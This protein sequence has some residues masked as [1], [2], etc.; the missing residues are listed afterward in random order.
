TSQGRRL[1]AH[2]LAHVVQN[3]QPQR[4]AVNPSIQRKIKVRGPNE[5][6]FFST[7]HEP[8]QKERNRFLARRFSGD[9]LAKRIV[10]DMADATDDFRFE[11][12]NE[13]FTEVFKRADTS[14]RMRE[15]QKDLGALGKAFGYPGVSSKDCGPR[16]NKAA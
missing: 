7:W 8:N 1:L 6:V 10:E 11:N 2:E 12:E 5:W 14:R 16:V 13:L 4:A 9:Q 3:S 15:S